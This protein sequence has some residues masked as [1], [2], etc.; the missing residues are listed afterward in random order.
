MVESEERESAS[1]LEETISKIDDLI[2]EGDLDGAREA[3][4]GALQ[5]QGS[6]GELL[7][8]RAE[9]ALESEEY[10]ECISAVE[11]GLSKIEDDETAAQL[12]A[13]TGYARFYLDEL[14]Q[15]RASFNEAVKKGG[16]FWSALVGRAMVHEDLLYFR[17]AMLDLDRAIELDDQEAQP[18]A[19]RGSIYLRR[20]EL[21]SARGDFSHAI[22]LD[23]EDEESRLNLARLLAIDQQTSE[24]VETLEPLVEEGEDPEFV[25]PAALLRSQL[26]LMLGST[27][28]AS[29]DAQ[30]AIDVAPDEPW[31]YLQLAA[32]HLTA[33]NA[34]D[35][36]AALKEAEDRV[37]DL[38]DLPD[39]YVLRASAYEQ[40]D[41]PEEAQQLRQ[42]AE[43]TARLPLI[44]Y[45]EWLN[46][47][48]NIPINP[49][50]PVDVRRLLSQI[51]GDPSNAP[52]GYEEAVREVI[53]QVP[54]M[55]Q[56]N[57]GV[58]QI[59]VELPHF[60]GMDEAP[61]SLVVQVGNK[62]GAAD[63]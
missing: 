50:K 31:G 36:I 26:S 62:K 10:G 3:I 42:E 32:S 46:P 16:A 15:A 8:L 9:V 25:M 48:Q 28:A 56:D 49:S 37:D 33:M 27:D 38:R 7:L 13:L 57:P 44:V 12:L 35:A 21:E 24:A 51:F 63:A 39:A 22:T 11:D 18:F 2:A 5:A 20:G 23:P 29:E 54:K 17:A 40:L 14:D 53:S 1:R 30:M 45:G 6:A 55:I 19:I 47:A 34:G 52:E 4:D 43:G 59:R 60:E 41:K 58:G 61:R